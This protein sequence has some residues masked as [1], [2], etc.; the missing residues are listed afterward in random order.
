M[1]YVIGYRDKTPPNGIVIN[2]TSR[3]TDW[4]QGLSPFYLNAGHLYGDY[5]ANIVENAWQ[6]SKVYEEHLDGYDITDKYWKWATNGWSKN[7][8]ERYPMGKGAKSLFSLWDGKRLGKVEARKEIYIPIYTRALEQ[9]EA[10]KGL[11]EVC[12]VANSTNTDIYLLDFDGFNH[13]KA[14]ISIEKII[15]NP[16][17]SLG[18]SFVIWNVLKTKYNLINI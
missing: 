12:E 4:S 1:I 11:L 7:Y 5:Y 17:K 14:N 6:Y 10:F 2:T 13:I 8:G 3:S 18:H 16:D 15:D 9:S